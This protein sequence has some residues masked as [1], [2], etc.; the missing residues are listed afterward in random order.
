M[1]QVMHSDQVVVD[2]GVDVDHDVRTIRM[3]INEDH[4]GNSQV[5]VFHQLY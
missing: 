5:L 1:P 2:L 3:E 4:F